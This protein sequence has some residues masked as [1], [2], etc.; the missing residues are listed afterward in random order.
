MSGQGVAK[1]QTKSVRK[2]RMAAEAGYDEAMYAYGRM[3]FDGYATH[4]NEREAFRLF[5]GAA[6][7]CN[8]RANF[9]QAVCCQDGRSVRPKAT[10]AK[11][12]LAQ[13]E[14]NGL[15]EAKVALGILEKESIPK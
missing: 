14:E 1:N 5:E 13:A 12:L 11:E 6:A 8:V 3:L 10:K 9:W 7:K 4:K 15:I 2:I